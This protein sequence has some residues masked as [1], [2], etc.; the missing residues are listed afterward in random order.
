[1]NSYNHYA[2]GSVADWV[3]GV[4]CGI[5]PA[6][7]GYAEVRI[8]PHPDPRLVH[9]GAV[10]SPSCYFRN[11]PLYCSQRNTAFCGFD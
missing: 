11:S 8:E 7:P 3:F 9:L 2:Y 5:Q 1:M 6:A 4:A 10:P